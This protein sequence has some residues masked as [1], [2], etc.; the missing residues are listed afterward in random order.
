MNELNKNEKLVLVGLCDEFMTES[1][2]DDFEENQDWKSKCETWGD[3]AIDNVKD[4]FSQFGYPQIKGYISQ[5]QQKGYIVVFQR[6]S[7][8]SIIRLTEK[9][10]EVIEYTGGYNWKIK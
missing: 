1:I 2:P 7:G 9:A 10:F 5:L 3:T 8:S 6:N 4:T